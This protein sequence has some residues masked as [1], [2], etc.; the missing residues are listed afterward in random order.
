M[1]L[2]F[3]YWYRFVLFLNISRV[4]RR[5]RAYPLP[6]L[7]KHYRQIL[8]LFLLLLAR[9]GMSSKN[10]CYHPCHLHIS[11]SCKIQK[12]HKERVASEVTDPSLSIAHTNDCGSSHRYPHSQ[13]Y[14]LETIWTI[15]QIPQSMKHNMHK[16]WPLCI[17]GRKS[18]NFSLW[19][20]CG[21]KTILIAHLFTFS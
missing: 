17:H 1:K 3:Y 16:Y 2:L 6:W 11:V 12:A 7:S 21:R 18:S 10:D 9:R 4:S 8:C 14:R 20:F 15:F 5:L 13:W 19:L